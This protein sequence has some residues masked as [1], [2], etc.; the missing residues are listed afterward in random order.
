MK[1]LRGSLDELLK[2]DIKFEWKKTH[3]KALLELKKGLASD[4]CL[5]HFDPKKRLFWRS[6]HQTMESTDR[7]SKLH[8]R[9]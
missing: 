9:R 4:L 6:T 7:E 8:F 5:T 1:E 3:D 2:K